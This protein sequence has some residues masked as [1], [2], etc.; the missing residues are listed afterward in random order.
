MSS[1]AAK[2]DARSGASHEQRRHPR[3]AVELPI[4]IGGPGSKATAHIQ[5]STSDVSVG[6]AFIR[7]DLLFEIGEALSLMFTLPDGRSVRAKGTVVRVS[8]GAPPEQQFDPGAE[9]PGMGIEF[10]SLP[11]TDRDAIRA[12]V[13]KS[14]RG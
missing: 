6:G 11:D 10:V 4:A 5:F 7:S 12:L 1:A 14:T 3:C 2:P 13:L 9:K 8:R